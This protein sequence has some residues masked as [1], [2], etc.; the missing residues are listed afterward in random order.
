MYKKNLFCLITIFLLGLSYLQVSAQAADKEIISTI[1]KLFESMR[2]GDTLLIEKIFAPNAQLLTVIEE[3]GKVSLHEVSIEK[4]K[5]AVA[6]PRTEVWDERI[7]S[8][9]IKVD[10][11]LASAWTPYEFYL[12][13]NFSHCGVNAFQLYKADDGWKILV[14]TDTRR[15]ENCP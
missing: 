7:K 11:R 8:Y 9:E 10:E 12:G 1:Q 14:I 13:Q 2:K 6:S 5:T 15:L 4:F 3:A